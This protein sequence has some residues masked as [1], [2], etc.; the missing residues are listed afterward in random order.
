MEKIRKYSLYFNWT[1]W[2][3]IGL[4]STTVFLIA[5]CVPGFFM[6]IYLFI[7]FER[8]SGGGAQREGENPKQALHCHC[9]AWCGVV[10]HEPQD[11]DLNQNEESEG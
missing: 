10:S 9:W 4:K 1:L 5:Y 2:I 11:H 7:Y 8:E 6:Y 3:T